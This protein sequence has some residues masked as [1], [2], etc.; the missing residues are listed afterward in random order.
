M[1]F[2]V[3]AGGSRD[4][5]LRAPAMGVQMITKLHAISTFLIQL[6]GLNRLVSVPRDSRIIQRPKNA[7]Y[8]VGGR[9]T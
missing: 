7:I 9:V 8:C 1:R 4:P 2:I 3:W 5:H 6:F